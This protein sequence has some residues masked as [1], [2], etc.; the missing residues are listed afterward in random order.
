MATKYTDVDYVFDEVHFGIDLKGARTK[1]DVT[2][3]ELDAI[4]GIESSQAVGQLERAQ[5]AQSLK[6]RHFLALC[7]MFNLK[8]SDYFDTADA[9][10]TNM[11]QGYEP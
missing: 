9:L 6:M 4:L 8:P 11:L 10:G 7:N 5:Y 1:A 2:Q 3:K